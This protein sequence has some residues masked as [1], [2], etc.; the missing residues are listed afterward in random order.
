MRTLTILLAIMANQVAYAQ[1]PDQVTPNVPIVISEY[2]SR[3]NTIY[4][5]GSTVQDIDNFLLQLHDDVRYLHV[6]YEADFDKTTWHAAFTRNHQAGSYAESA[7]HC[8]AITNA[9]AGKNYHAV[10]Y[11]YGLLNADNCEPQ[12]D[13]RL[14]ILFG[15]TE[16]KISLVQE[17][18]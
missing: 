3:L 14:L 2:F 16:G 13:D 7:T 9:I 1:K 11:T 12:N 4:Q 18:W 10:E 8:I 17:L 15:F 6:N 5:A